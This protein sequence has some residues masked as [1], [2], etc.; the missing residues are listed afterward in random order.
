MTILNTMEQWHLQVMILLVQTPNAFATKNTCMFGITDVCKINKKI[1][2]KS[3]KTLFDFI[4]K[5][6]E[7]CSNFQFKSN[8]LDDIKTF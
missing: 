3:Q 6:I 1:C 5:G 7:I 2:W 8:H 4:I